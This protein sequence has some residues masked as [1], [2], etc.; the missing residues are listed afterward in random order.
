MTAGFDFHAIHGIN[1][2]KWNSALLTSDWNA[3]PL[4]E[5]YEA[6]LELIEASKKTGFYALHFIFISGTP[7]KKEGSLALYQTEEQGE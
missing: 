2:E 1:G 7:P 5:F 6:R 3:L 4:D